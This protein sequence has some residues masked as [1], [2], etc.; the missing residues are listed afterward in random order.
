MSNFTQLSNL[1]TKYVTNCIV[2]YG[3]VNTLTIGTGQCR[4][5]TNTFDIVI[6]SPLVISSLASASGLPNGLDTGTIAANT[7]YAV[8]AIF[9][10]SN[11]VP[12]AGLISLSG[13]APIM[14]SYNGVTYGAFRLLGWMRTNGSGNFLPATITGNGNLR[15]HYW[16]A[17]IS[18]LS[19]GAATTFAQVN[20]GGAAPSIDN[21]E[22]T[23]DA[24]FT[25][26]AAGNNVNFR[27]TTSTATQVDGFT[28]TNAGV[29]QE[30]QIKLLTKLS[31]NAPS[32]DYK[33]SAAGG[34]T[35]L[36][37]RGFEYFI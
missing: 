7:W 4:D 31:S 27:P 10:P 6:S 13:T 19:A 15:K 22:L 23:F 9:D 21:I 33:N 36:F 14:P 12:V 16:D 18:V 5:S 29:V 28:G 25:P 30:L 11:F 35:T 1:S 20:C 32:L 8:F 3:T 34:S 37:V 24:S 17:G 26:A 2:S